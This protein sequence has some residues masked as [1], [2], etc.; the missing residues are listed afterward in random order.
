MPGVDDSSVAGHRCGGGLP[1]SPA[2]PAAIAA[3]S[4]GPNRVFKQRI[5]CT[6]A[7]LKHEIAEVPRVR[8]AAA[9][10]QARGLL[11]E[12]KGREYWYCSAPKVPPTVGGLVG[13]LEF[14]KRQ[15]PVLYKFKGSVDVPGSCVVSTDDLLECVSRAA[16]LV[17][18]QITLSLTTQVP[19]FLGYYLSDVDLRLLRKTVLQDLPGGEGL[20]K[21]ALSPQPEAGSKDKPWGQEDIR[22]K[23]GP[24]LQDRLSSDGYQTT[25]A[26]VSKFLARLVEEY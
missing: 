10:E 17:P 12:E 2:R 22:T 24:T 1:A 16:A 7:W 11:A 5:R 14:V 15:S 4:H 25:F 21:F 3:G 23:L 18:S 9:A 8:H 6:Y 19:L 26:D 13:D 20:T